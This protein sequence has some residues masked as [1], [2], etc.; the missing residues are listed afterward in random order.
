[1]EKHIL[2]KST[3]I[4]GVQCLK[5]L[6]LNKKR[7]FL[8]DKIPQERLLVFKRGHKVGEMAH[9]LFPGGINMSPGHPSAYRKAVMRTQEKIKEGYPVIYEAA[10]QYDQV[11]I[12]LDILVHTKNGWH[13]YEVKS[14]ASISDTYLMDAALQYYVIRG[15]GL[16]INGIS[17]IHIN[18]EYV[19]E[20]E[21]DVH[22]LFTIVDVTDEALSRHEYVAEQIRKEKETLLLPNSPAI[23]V[24][25]HCHEPYD[26]DFIG[27]C[28]KKIPKPD[29]TPPIDQIDKMLSRDAVE[30]D[31]AHAFIKLLPI[32]PA[33][34]MYKGTRPYQEIMYGYSLK[35][36]SAV[37]MALFDHISN[38][39]EELTGTL[40]RQL[41]GIK[42]LYCFGQAY[43]L[44][45]LI[46]DDIQIIDMQKLI[47]PESEFLNEMKDKSNLEKL[48]LIFSSSKGEIL[49]EYI[50]DDISGHHYL[51][52]FGEDATKEKLAEYATA[53]VEGLE[54]F[55]EFC[56]S[57][58]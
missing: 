31:T 6:Y 34:P 27:H 10:F 26:C 53:W 25:P 15:T 33:I 38:P 23:E 52:A 4:R 56:R 46:E 3:F 2:S 35:N 9:A 32:R 28:W 21:I 40:S 36:E 47:L 17:I 24:G 13:A 45:E 16:E 20:E 37:E 8:R 7:P 58:S 41:K 42:K 30:H 39:E 11:M 12:L 51:T 29:K 57:V 5:S 50:S 48:L 43:A 55:F 1:M 19:R 14:S 18:R 44:E 22:Q 49:P 54:G